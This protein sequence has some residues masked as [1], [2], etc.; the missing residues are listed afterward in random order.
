MSN[1][2]N[3][4]N[5]IKP[6]P[7]S[8][9]YPTLSRQRRLDAALTTLQNASAGAF[10]ACVENSGLLYLKMPDHKLTTH[11]SA[12]F[13]VVHLTAP[14]AAAI[15]GEDTASQFML[16]GREL[17]QTRLG[18]KALLAS[19]VAHVAASAAKRVLASHRQRWRLPS[20]HSLS[21]WHSVSGFALVPI[22]VLHTLK[23]RWW[24]A[25][26]DISPAFF[27][28]GYVVR[29]LQTRPW[30]S[31]L[32]YGSILLAGSYHWIAGLRKI[33]SQG[34]CPTEATPFVLVRRHHHHTM[35]L[36]GVCVFLHRTKKSVVA[37][38][39]IQV[40]LRGGGGLGWLGSDQT[41][42]GRQAVPAHAARQMGRCVVS[43]PVV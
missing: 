1:S 11:C 27:N 3:P 12:R 2:S 7:A 36:K 26:S 31:W 33:L 6:R 23:H 10:G 14:A 20:L 22:V 39:T 28:Y 19:G 15:G 18:E 5:E 42:S 9:P 24:P 38:K 30:L 32:G 35:E 37:R 4:S 41:G 8:E 34:V 13:M 21:S 17:Y 16:L 29:A 40:G 25:A 43:K